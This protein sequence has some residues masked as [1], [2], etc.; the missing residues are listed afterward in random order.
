M[1]KKLGYIVFAVF[2]TIFRIWPIQKNKVFL[3]A[4]HDDSEEGNVGIVAEEIRKK[5]P[6]KKMV[7][8]TRRDGIRHPFTFFFE[9]AFHMATAGTIFLDNHFMPMA[10]TPISKKVDVVQLWHGTGTIK[11]FGLDAEDEEV[12]RLAQK[13]NNRTTHL[14]VGSDRTKR[15]YQS[16][17][18]IPEERI[19]VLGL[20]RTDRILDDDWMEKRRCLFFQRYPYLEDKRRILYAPTFRDEES[21]HPK[22]ALN[23]G[24]VAEKLAEDEVLLLRLHPHVEKNADWSILDECGGKICNVSDY[25]GVATLLAVADMLITDYSSI[26]FEYCLCRKPMC[27]YAYDLEHFRSHGRGFYEDYETFVPGPVVRTQEELMEFIAG[28]EHNLEKIDSFCRENFS[29]HDKKAVERLLHLIFL[30]R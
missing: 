20:P 22:I 23:L 25:P 21:E 17:F 30:Q 29:F 6:G 14:I 15:Q 28:R 3:V 7:F 16:A 24:K 1:K 27:F 19:Y 9:K 11:K 18:G 4:T 8:L 10:Y 13:A 26:I 5:I 2:F 12:A